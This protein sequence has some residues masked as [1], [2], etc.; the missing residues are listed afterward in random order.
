M[1][2]TYRSFF[3]MTREAFDPDLS[4]KDILETQDI[5]P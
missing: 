4:L 3:G 2:A 5:A 1:S